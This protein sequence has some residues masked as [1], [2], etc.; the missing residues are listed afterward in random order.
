[1][2]KKEIISTEHAPAAVGSYS[3]AIKV[4]DFLF[5]SGQLGLEPK[6]GI[7]AGEIE[8]QTRAALNN[9][10][11]ILKAGKSSLENV[12]KVNI[13]LKNMG[14]FTKVNAIY[15]EFF[16][17]AFPARCCIEVGSLPKDSMIEIEAIA[18][19]KNK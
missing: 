6:T 16:T 9:V 15:S 17:S 19:C 14:D 4:S 2:L 10:K 18:L 5:V 8:A 7:L 1:M 11:E 13:Y 3:Q 12:V